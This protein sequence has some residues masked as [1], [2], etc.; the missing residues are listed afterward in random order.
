MNFTGFATYQ[1]L[2]F[3]ATGLLVI[4]LSTLED[5]G[6]RLSGGPAEEWRRLGG[7][8]LLPLLPERLL[9][10]FGSHRS[11]LAAA[12]AS[13]RGCSLPRSSWRP[14]VWR[15]SARSQDGQYGRSWR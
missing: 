7:F 13:P 14:C 5:R 12:T 15:G 2:A 3:P 1:H 9:P 10:L 8:R 4:T 11:R 6:R